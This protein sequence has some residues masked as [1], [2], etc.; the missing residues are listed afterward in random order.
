VKNPVLDTNTLVRF[1]TGEP[2]DQ[3]REVA[4]LIAAAEAGKIQL[5][6]LPMVL[7]ETVSVLNGLTFLKPKPLSPHIGV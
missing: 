1:V 6:V 2:E 4:D 5:C 3:A 7:A